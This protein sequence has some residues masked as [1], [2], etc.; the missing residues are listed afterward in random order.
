MLSSKIWLRELLVDLI[1]TDF[2]TSLSDN[3][4]LIHGAVAE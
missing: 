4:C 1:I 3:F 2:D